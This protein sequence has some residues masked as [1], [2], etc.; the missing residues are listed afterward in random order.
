MLA[1]LPVLGNADLILVPARAELEPEA[2]KAVVAQ[3][4][5]RAVLVLAGPG[6][7]G[8]GGEGEGESDEG[9]D[10]DEGLHLERQERERVKEM[11]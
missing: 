1:A 9:G 6:R 8:G 5:A 4:L 7:F 10:G 3:D 2:V 11:R